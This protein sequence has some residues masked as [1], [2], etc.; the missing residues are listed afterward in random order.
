MDRWVTVGSER[1]PA[2]ETVAK[3]VPVEV[4]VAKQAQYGTRYRVLLE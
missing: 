3:Q 1:L 2:E 4:T